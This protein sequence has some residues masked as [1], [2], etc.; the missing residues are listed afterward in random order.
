MYNLL[1]TSLSLAVLK[2]HFL[3]VNFLFVPFCSMS[4]TE[5]LIEAP[6]IQLGCKHIY[7]Y[8]CVVNSLK[9]GPSVSYHTQSPERRKVFESFFS[10]G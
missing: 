1:C 4:Q 3:W 6:C 10:T 5:S 8:Q 2:S 7:H 9:A